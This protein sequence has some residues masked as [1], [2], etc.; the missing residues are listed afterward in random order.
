MRPPRVHPMLAALVTEG[1]LSV[2]GRVFSDLESCPHCGGEVSGYDTKER[3]FAVVIE[4]DAR[5]TVN[6][7]VKRYSCTACGRVSPARAPFYPG[8]RHGSP[9]VDLCVALSRV[10]T[11]GRAAR[12]AACLGISVDKNTVR[13]YARGA[14]PAIP[15]EPLFGIPLPRSLLSLSL[16]AASRR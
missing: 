9:V 5:R 12:V 10:M 8:T 15:V 14:F 7:R 3:R 1:I 13:S 16:T 4:G 6:V 2:G 11:P